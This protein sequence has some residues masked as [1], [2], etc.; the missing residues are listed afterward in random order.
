M[1]PCHRAQPS[2]TARGTT[3]QLAAPTLAP[4]SLVDCQNLNLAVEAFH[5]VGTPVPE[6]QTRSIDQIPNGACRQDLPGAGKCHDAGG[7]MQSD[8]HKAAPQHLPFADMHS[9]A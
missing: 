6:G 5:R 3:P 7:K 8:P 2:S 9:S 1:M 4:S